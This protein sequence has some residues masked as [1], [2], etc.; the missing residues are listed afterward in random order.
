MP[1]EF[2]KAKITESNRNYAKAK[3]LEI[4]EKSSQRVDPADHYD[5]G[6]I[7]LEHL[8]YDAQLDFKRDVILQ[9]LEKFKPR[10]YE[11]LSCTRQS[12]WLIRIIIATRRLFRS[13]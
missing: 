4:V 13:G 12:E 7:E 10:G 2:V 9:A 8:N 5:V 11:K 6:G 1:K 3:L